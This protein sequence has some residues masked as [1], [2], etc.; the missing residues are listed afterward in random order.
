[1]DKISWYLGKTIIGAICIVMT[2]FVGLE[3]LF[4]LVN[5]LRFVGTGNYTVAGAVI[6]TLLSAPAQITQMFPLSALIGTLLGLGLLASRSELIVM[7]AAGWSIGNIIAAVCKTAL[8]FIIIMW[9]VGE[10]VAPELERVANQQKAIALSEG[11]ALKTAHGLWMRDGEY[12]V[13]I[14]K[15]E[16]AK[17]LE[18]ITRYEFNPRMELQ[19]TSFARSAEYQD[20]HWVLHDI[21]ETLFGENKIT[22]QSKTQ[23]NWVSHIDPQILSMVGEKEI[24]TLSLTGLWQTMRFQKNNALDARAYEL[25][26]WQKLTQPLAIL[27]MMFLAIPFIFGP[28]R[29]ATMGLRMLV[30]ILIGFSFYTVNQ[31]FGPLTLVYHVPPI[32]GA[33]FP[34]LLFFIAGVFL[35][36][37]TQ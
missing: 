24:A 17:H 36:R 15:V 4:S 33:V 14:Q 22:Q 37:R 27:V 6:H 23:Q 8:L 12:F 34:T 9:F 18:G 30:G 31:L 2:L 13:H 25:T 1:M 20:H 11:Q 10:W 16:N 26:F 7:R 32:I 19:K 3:S 28:L 5:E 35:L 29:S 21:Q